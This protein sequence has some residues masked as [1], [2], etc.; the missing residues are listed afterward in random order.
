MSGE[1]A[2]ADVLIVDDHGLL[3][4]SLTFALRAEGLQVDRCRELTGPAIVG[5]VE[6]AQ[7]DVVLL[8]LDLGGEVGASTE[9][10]PTLREAGSS[11]VM[12]TGVTDR[13]RL[14]A[15]V[16]AGAVGVIPK[17][18]PFERLVAGVTRAVEV[19]TLLT[20]HERDELLA[21]LRRSRETE[22]ARRQPFEELTRREAEV[23]AA[24][25]EGQSAERIARD[26]F[27]S[28][29]TVR[30]QI[31]SLRLKLGAGSQ[32]EAVAMARH[33]GWELEQNG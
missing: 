8:D 4:Q 15:C 19:G 1:A 25:M 32:L 30:S 2:T 33:A 23:L 11:V 5:A 31:K 26:A 16:E 13:T 7:P 29:A 14:A 18:D 12:L 6:S 9:L 28:L 3:A 17:S 27:V 21:E 10:I 24:L 20:R 22:R